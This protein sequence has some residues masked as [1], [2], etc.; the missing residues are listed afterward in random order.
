M[1]EFLVL[2]ST[3]SH[4]PVLTII[5]ATGLLLAFGAML[6]RMQDVLFGEPSGTYHPVTASYVPLFAHLS[7]VLTAGLFLPKPLLHWF[8]QTAALLQ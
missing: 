6:M 5:L 8:Q 2:S 4:S 3:F 1:S 7:L